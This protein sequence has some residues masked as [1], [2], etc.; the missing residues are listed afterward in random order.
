MGQGNYEFLLQPFSNATDDVDE[1]TPNK[2]LQKNI[3]KMVIQ[4]MTILPI[5]KL[6]MMTDLKN[7][8]ESNPSKMLHTGNPPKSVSL[9]R[10]MSSIT[11]KNGH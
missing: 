5:I 8:N 11:A 9:Q 1:P 2:M 10:V 3:I 7:V 4:M 6:V